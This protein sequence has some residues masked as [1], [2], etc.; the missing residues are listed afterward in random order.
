MGS[1]SYGRRIMSVET[2]MVVDGLEERMM[3]EGFELKAEMLGDGFEAGREWHWEKR[4]L[5]LE[6]GAGT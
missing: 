4:W 2:E 1:I 6:K 3:G 5:A